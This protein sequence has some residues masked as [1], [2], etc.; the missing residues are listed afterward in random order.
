MLVGAGVRTPLLRMEEQEALSGRTAPRSTSLAQPKAP[1]KEGLL[2][3][4][5]SLC[6]GDFYDCLREAGPSQ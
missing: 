2:G 1:A 5:H 6:I 3:A 4:S